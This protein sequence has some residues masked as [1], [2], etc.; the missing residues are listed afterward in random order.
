MGAFYSYGTTQAAHA[1]YERAS[2]IA[3]L[4]VL[5][6]HKTIGLLSLLT[7]SFPGIAS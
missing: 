7:H 6:A 5:S 1:V 4:A 2:G 3:N